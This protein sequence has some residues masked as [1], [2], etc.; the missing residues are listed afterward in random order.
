[1]QQLTAGLSGMCHVNRISRAGVGP[2]AV[3]MKSSILRLDR[4][5]QRAAETDTW[6]NLQNEFTAQPPHCSR[7][8]NFANSSHVAQ[9]GWN[10]RKPSARDIPD[11]L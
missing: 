8:A 10:Q 3:T 6:K 5:H 1:L 9:A 4:H 7:I 2:A 11:G